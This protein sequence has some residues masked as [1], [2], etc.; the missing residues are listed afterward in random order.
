M[1]FLLTQ[2]VLVVV[3]VQP[4]VAQEMAQQAQ[5]IKDMPEVM[6]LPVPVLAVAVAQV[7]QAFFQELMAKVA[8]EVPEFLLQ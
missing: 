6:E 2:E 7:E 3:V 1:I 5:Q 8:L 4:L